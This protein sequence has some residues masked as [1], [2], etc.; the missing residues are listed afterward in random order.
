MTDQ[1]ESM[2]VWQETLVNDGEYE[3]TV[4]SDCDGSNEKRWRRLPRR[5]VEASAWEEAS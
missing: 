4:S 5:V 2:P 1:R 3:Y